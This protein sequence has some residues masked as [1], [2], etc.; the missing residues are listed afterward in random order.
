M[1]SFPQNKRSGIRVGGRG[2][3]LG[4]SQDKD[5]RVRVSNCFAETPVEIVRKRAT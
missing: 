2:V 1:I 3:P 5:M 4:R